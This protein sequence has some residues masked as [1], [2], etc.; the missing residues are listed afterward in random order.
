[1]VA[2]PF[3][4]SSTPGSKPGE[5][6]GRLVNV[7]CEPNGD[8]NVWKPAPGLVTFG[9]IDA[10]GPR[11]FQAL[12]GNIYAAVK[13]QLYSVTAGGT[14]SL[15]GGLNG[16]L[17]VHFERNTRADGP[18]VVCVTED[19]AF[20]VTPSS[21]DPY[22][23]G[24]LPQ[25]NSVA[26][27]NQRFLFTIGDGR[28][29]ASGVNTTAIDALAFA[30]A[31]SNPD[32]LFRG[33]VYGSNYFVFGPTTTEV[34]YDA[35]TT[36]FSLAR[37][38]VIPIGLAG[39]YAIA[40]FGDGWDG[41]PLFVANNGTVRMMEGY[42]PRLVSTPDVERAIAAI[43]DKST[44]HAS[45]YTFAGN[46]I[47]S[48]S[49]PLW[50]WEYNLRTGLWHER[51]SLG[52]NRWRGSW[53]VRAFDKWLVGDSET[54]SVMEVVPGSRREGV[55]QIRSRVESVPLMGFPNRVQVPAA[56]FR[57]AVGQGVAAGIDPIEKSPRVKISWSHD[58]S[59]N[60]SNP[61]ER[62]LGGEGR[63]DTTVSV[64]RCGLSTRHGVQ[65][66]LDVSDPVY[67]SLLDG[68][69]EG[70]ARTP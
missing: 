59:G 47:W 45:A 63:Y 32:P 4:R 30:K 27:L 16:D 3:P 61:L 56:H 10:E 48:L 26:N 60:W 52:L 25:P 6:Q 23:D 33:I 38:T 57:F 49:S 69:I 2:I 8:L 66:R 53:A 9:A 18:D 70:N 43:A 5:S 41:P 28:I 68:A 20:V 46:P 22:P 1:M 35:A 12:P 29:F 7:Y 42:T 31:E 58:G 34:W 55:D 21:V 19:G 51:D 17:P 64:Y 14:V 40:G 54:G 36:P 15:V 11:G 65:F 44:L 62:S 37:Q 13:D 39:T 24:D 67:F 50:T